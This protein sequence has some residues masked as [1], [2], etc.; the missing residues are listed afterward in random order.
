MFLACGHITFMKGGISMF[1]IGIDVGKFKHCCAV[2]DSYGEVIIDPFFFENNI[3]GFSSLFKIIQPYQSKT[4]LSGLESTGHYGDNLARFLLNHNFNVGLINPLTTD[5]FRK[6]K[7]RKTKN[8]AIDAILI[9]NVLYSRDYTQLTQHKLLLHEAKQLT[10][11]R[12][13]LTAS[14]NVLKNQ[15]QA[16]IDLV[17]PEY[18]SLFKTK[19]SRAYMAVLKEFPSANAIATSHLTKLKFTILNASSK[20]I[21]P[22][23]PEK[24]KTLAKKSIGEHNPIIELQI[25]QLLVSIEL[26]NQQLSEVDSQLNDFAKRLNSPIFSIP[27]IGITTGMSILGEIND[28]HLFSSSAKLIAFA[29]CDPAVYQSG[30]YNAPHTVISKRGSRHLRYALYN[31]A[32]CVCNFNPVF[33][34]YYHKKREQGKS[35]RCAQGHVVRKMLRVIYKLLSDDICFDSSALR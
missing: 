24:L 26:V 8:D 28:I 35:H 19:Y 31:A 27:G 20:R 16:C 18:N 7:L 22:S 3:D 30:E 17:F 12:H 14:L 33:N 32:L 21:N 1:F 15:L 25:K 29:G 10:R 6:H 9:C 5:A 34:S 23:Y 2:V 13:D 11:Y 4:H